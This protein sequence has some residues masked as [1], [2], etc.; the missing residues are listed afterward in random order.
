MWIIIC[1][2]NPNQL[3]KSGYWLSADPAARKLLVFFCGMAMYAW[4]KPKNSARIH[5][6]SLSHTHQPNTLCVDTLILFATF[7]RTRNAAMRSN[8]LSWCSF[9]FQEAT[10]KKK[11]S[12]HKKSP[13]KKTCD[14]ETIVQSRCCGNE[15]A[16]GL[17]VFRAVQT[18]ALQA[19]ASASSTEV[20]GLNGAFTVNSI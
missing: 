4:H 13:T 7:F 2:N 6:R 15:K 8:S 5:H 1:F 11:T 17:Q 10:K 20:F 19:V 18:G 3:V 12:H 14:V 16:S 9:I